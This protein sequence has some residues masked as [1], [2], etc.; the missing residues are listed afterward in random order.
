MGISPP[1]LSGSGPG[2]L[3]RA[4]S[5]F[6]EGRPLRGG[7]CTLVVSRRAPE[8][9]NL[10]APVERGT[11]A[12]GGRCFFP[13]GGVMSVVALGCRGKGHVESAG[14]LSL[15]GAGPVTP[16]APRLGSPPGG[17]AEELIAGRLAALWGQEDTDVQ[18]FGSHG[19]R[20]DV[21]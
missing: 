10:A 15:D 9:G 11:S 16:G 2:P 7:G 18:E 6:S 12:S 19:K 4:F 13:A 1:I 17:I 3:G 14:C 21:I 5:F 20:E 8:F